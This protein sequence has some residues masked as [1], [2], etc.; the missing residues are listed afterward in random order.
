MAFFGVAC[1]ATRERVR[2]G[3]ASLLL[4]HMVRETQ[5]TDGVSNRILRTTPALSHRLLL[6]AS[7]ARQLEE[8]TFSEN[9][10]RQSA[11]R[12]ADT[13]LRREWMPR[14]EG[15]VT[16]SQDATALHSYM[17]RIVWIWHIA[18]TQARP[19]LDDADNTG[20]DEELNRERQHEI[21]HR[22]VAQVLSRGRREQGFEDAGRHENAGLFNVLGSGDVAQQGL[23]PAGV[24]QDCVMTQYSV[25]VVGAQ[26]ASYGP[27]QPSPSAFPGLSS[28]W[29]EWWRAPSQFPSRFQ[30]V[31]FFVQ[32]DQSTHSPFLA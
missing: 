30:C 16:V 31:T 17:W 6:R 15:A 9:T 5:T 1:C 13:V 19:Q 20:T 29:L 24:A 21:L 7:P 18:D 10:G 23:G 14:S 26:E 12:I 8:Q 11:D 3:L 27:S 28:S 32:S 22:S 4:Q 2:C 25:S